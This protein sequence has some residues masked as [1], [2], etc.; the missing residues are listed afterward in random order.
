M[1]DLIVCQPGT[2]VVVKYT[3]KTLGGFFEGELGP[4]GG[5][6][7]YGWGGFGG[8]L[9]WEGFGGFLGWEGFGFIEYLYRDIHIR[10]RRN[11]VSE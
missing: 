11:F 4:S 2:L 9:G 10:Y 5:F 7:G 8:F 1:D 3:K 6:L